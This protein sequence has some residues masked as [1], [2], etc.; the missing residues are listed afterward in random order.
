MASLIQREDVR[1]SD[2]LPAGLAGEKTVGFG[3]KI[4]PG[5]DRTGKL[6]LE[7]ENVTSHTSRR[8]AVASHRSQPRVLDLTFPG[9]GHSFLLSFLH[10]PR[11]NATKGKVKIS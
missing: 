5:I 6:E 8:V 11:L 7:G 1:R 10:R 3:L 9:S 2:F 4:S